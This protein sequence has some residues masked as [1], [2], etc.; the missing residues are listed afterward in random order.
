MALN[1]SVGDQAWLKNLQGLLGYAYVA[2]F[3]DKS[4]VKV[5]S[6]QDHS[7]AL[8]FDVDL[9]H[10]VSPLGTI[11]GVHGST[12][13]DKKEPAI[14][15]HAVHALHKPIPQDQ[16]VQNLAQKDEIQITG[17]TST[18]RLA[19]AIDVAMDAAGGKYGKDV[20]AEFN[21]VLS[22]M[23]ALNRVEGFEDL[24]LDPAMRASPSADPRARADLYSHVAFSMS[25]ED[26][27]QNLSFVERRA[28]G[29]VNDILAGRAPA[30][31]ASQQ[32]FFDKMRGGGYAWSKQGNLRPTADRVIGTS[33]GGITSYDAVLGSGLK[34][35][36]TKWSIDKGGIQAFP[37]V[38]T[39]DEG[40]AEVIKQ[41][42]PGSSDSGALYRTS[43]SILPGEKSPR[44][45]EVRT[46]VLG[47]T[48]LPGA[49]WRYYNPET[50][51]QR[52]DMYIREGVVRKSLPEGITPEA[53]MR[54]DIKFNFPSKRGQSYGFG[55][56]KFQVGKVTIGEK[57]HD[58]D[59]SKGQSP[60][61]ASGEQV[62]ALPKYYNPVRAAWSMGGQ[63]GDVST[64]KMIS[65]LQE[66]NPTLSFVADTLDQVE[67]RMRGNFQTAVRTRGDG[68]KI[69]EAPT[70]QMWW[71]EKAD[72]FIDIFTAE[73]KSPK[74]LTGWYEGASPSE[75]S[76]FLGEWS[77]LRGEGD[78]T[79]QAALTSATRQLEKS[80]TVDWEKVN[81]AYR[82]ASK[83]KYGG[84]AQELRE[85]IM[86]ETVIEAAPQDRVLNE[87]LLGLGVG[88]LESNRPIDLG[89]MT[90]TNFD[91]MV[92]TLE[93]AY[94]NEGFSKEEAAKKARERY[95]LGNKQ[96]ETGMPIAQEHVTE[97]LLMIRTAESLVS[98]NAT[99]RSSENIAF[100]QSITDLD[101]ELARDIGLHVEDFERLGPAERSSASLYSWLLHTQDIKHGQGSSLSPA[102]VKQMSREDMIAIDMLRDQEGMTNSEYAQ[103]IAAQ[104]GIA[105]EFTML[106]VGENLLPNPLAIA[107]KQ[108]EEY[109]QEIGGLSKD[110]RKA[111]EGTVRS[112]LYEDDPILRGSSQQQAQSRLYNRIFGLREGL[113]ENAMSK[114]SASGFTFLQTPFGAVEG[115]SMGQ[116]MLEPLGRRLAKKFKQPFKRAMDFLQQN[117]IPMGANRFPQVQGTA[118]SLDVAEHIP[119]SR[120]EQQIGSE[121]FA[122]MQ[123]PRDYGTVKSGFQWAVKL[124][125]DFDR[126]IGHGA[127]FIKKGAQGLMSFGQEFIKRGLQS[128]LDQEKG[129][130]HNQAARDSANAFVQSGID[131]VRGVNVAAKAMAKRTT[132]PYRELLEQTLNISQPGKN[133]GIGYNIGSSLA[134]AAEGAGISSP[135]IYGIQ[136][137]YSQALD[138][139]GARAPA[140]S[141]A[142]SSA[143]FSHDYDK[144]GSMFLGYSTEQEDSDYKKSKRLEV[145]I[146]EGGIEMRGMQEFYSQYQKDV[147][148][149]IDI[150]DG[151]DV[152]PIGP[153]TAASMFARDDEHYG[154]LFQK[155]SGMDQSKWAGELVSDTQAYYDDYS[156][157]PNDARAILVEKREKDRTIAS[158][159]GM[160]ALFGRA[161]S[162]I[163]QDDPNETQLTAAAGIASYLTGG[164]PDE[165]LQDWRAIG[166]RDQTLRKNKYATPS[167]MLGASSFGALGKPTT[168]IGRA[169][170]RLSKMFG[171]VPK[172]PATVASPVTIQSPRAQIESELFSPNI[173]PERKQE[174]ITQARAMDDKNLP[175]AEMSDASLVNDLRDVVSQATPVDDDSWDATQARLREEM[176]EPTLAES[177]ASA[178]GGGDSGRGG[179]GTGGRGGDDG[180]FG[181]G[182]RFGPRM[183]AEKA[184]EMIAKAYGGLT[185]HGQ[186]IRAA[187]SDIRTELEPYGFGNV[188]AWE[189]LDKL[190]MTDPKAAAAIRGRHA[191]VSK[192]ALQL[193]RDIRS[194][195]A[196]RN[197]SHFMPDDPI[198][199]QLEA[200]SVGPTGT[201][202]S[203]MGGVGL[204]VISGDQKIN[205]ALI[206]MVDELQGSEGFQDL[207]AQMQEAGV[208]SGAKGAMLSGMRKVFAS[209]PA[210]K[211]MVNRAMRL[212]TAVPEQLR[213]TLVGEEMSQIAD[214]G[215]AAKRSSETLMKESN[216]QI[217]VNPETL[218][219]IKGLNE[220]IS[221]LE[222]VAKELTP[223]IG[224]MTKEQ[225]KQR[226]EI[227][228]NIDLRK[229]EAGKIT[230][231]AVAEAARERAGELRK[232]W[233]V[234]QDTATLDK[235]AKLD[236]TASQQQ[237]IAEQFQTEEE[238]AN[239][240]P[241]GR[242]ARRMLGGFGLMYARSVFNLA[243]SGLGWGQG[244]RQEMEN[245]LG[246]T[247]YQRLGTLSLPYDQGRDL[248]NQTALAGQAY[249]PLTGF[250]QLMAE[251]PAA[252]DV[253]NIGGAGMGAWMYSQFAASTMKGQPMGKFLNDYSGAIGVGT[254][255]V[256]GIADIYSRAQDPWGLGTRL[257]R[258][259]LF[260]PMDNLASM[261]MREMA[262]EGF[263]ESER[264][265]AAT[266]LMREQ[267]EQGGTGGLGEFEYTGR[268]QVTDPSKVVGVDAQ[269]VF[270]RG[271]LYEDYTTTGSLSKFEE[272]QLQAQEMV[273]QGAAPTFEAAGL[274]AAFRSVYMPGM[275]IN[276]Q[277]LS[278]LATDY[279]MGGRAEKQAIGA[280]SLFDA[281]AKEYAGVQDGQ[282]KLGLL[283][284]GFAE[285]Q[286]DQA[287]QFRFDRGMQF[288]G[289]LSGFR[290]SQEMQD[291]TKSVMGGDPEAAA[292]FRDLMFK[293][294]ELAETPAGTA[295][296]S[297][298][299]AATISR[300][301]G[302]RNVEMPRLSD[303]S[304]DM[305][306]Y[307]AE[308]MASAARSQS[309]VAEQ[310][311][312]MAQQFR[313]QSTQYGRA[314][315]G[316][317]IFN[318]ITSAPQGQEWLLNRIY[319]LD[320][321]AMAATLGPGDWNSLPGVTTMNGT[322]MSASA[323]GFTDFGLSG[324][325]TG[326][327][328]GTS[329]LQMGGITG[330]QMA[331]NIFG[332][333]W[334][335][336][337]AFDQ[338]LIRGMVGGVS[339]GGTVTTLDGQQVSSVGGMMGAS[340]Y[341]AKVNRD[342]E[343]FQIGLQ[344]ER[345][346]LNVSHTKQMWGIE[347]K[348]RQLSYD[349]QM[350]NFAFQQENLDRSEYFGTAF[351][352]MN[353]KQSLMQREWT[354][355]DWGYSDQVRGLQWGWKQED[356]AEES[357]F[358]TGR[359]RRK[360]ERQNERDTTLHNLEGD[361]IDRQ[362]G[363][364][365][366][367]WKLED[368]RH[369]LQK[370][371][372]EENLKMQ[373]RQLNASKEYYEENFKLQE[374]QT[375]LSR[376]HHEAEIALQR[377]AAAAAAQHAERQ[378]R[379]QQTMAQVQIA[380]QHFQGTLKTV[381]D[382]GLES[383][384]AKLLELNPK[385]LE[386][387]GYLD[388]ISKIPFGTTGGSGGGG[389]AGG[390]GGGGL[391]GG[392]GPKP[393]SQVTA[394]TTFI[395]LNRNNGSQQQVINIYLAGEKIQS[396]IV[397]TITKEIS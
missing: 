80:G 247:G 342:Y 171:I 9:M 226:E 77:G 23:Y 211:E 229:H 215:A 53:L 128:V 307:Q 350:Q 168:L 212:R 75:L 296:S 10:N 95:S 52:P 69:G 396:F 105:D 141:S 265:R 231:S 59:W 11:V 389:G 101:E 361:Q 94:L 133:M 225:E 213:P 310:R 373:Q 284:L 317:G 346:D 219:R 263:E 341:Q 145:G 191:T 378:Y 22:G 267:Y 313:N 174:L 334:Q 380:T 236:R 113:I 235:I 340:L 100:Q 270:S 92:N 173:T 33:A 163:E 123:D 201:A 87:R 299:D 395:P 139:P 55:D 302:I 234:T 51:E 115:Y 285:L 177:M 209:N 327:S 214:Y 140:L 266:I 198:I 91:I 343:L 359:A 110:Y 119:E 322:Q 38:R 155:L 25:S 144:E 370:Q 99:A 42:E 367:L 148:A 50:A 237:G 220:E 18:N 228:K 8:T 295:L 391:G 251:T 6:V 34:I 83:G 16:R 374:R 377:R 85:M 182:R 204:N 132:M 384:K 147:L 135:D 283:Q 57:E 68:W 121:T 390:G 41:M 253:L 185:R 277:R 194:A 104:A 372:F 321:I 360:A 39:L 289:S 40:G 126:D 78:A 48:T 240:G 222:K 122:R 179:S 294:E 183:S 366:E 63:E 172:T 241:M 280:M 64:S 238:E 279:A 170:H 388:I 54:G 268:R 344:N 157:D 176:G 187:F 392:G 339:L 355:E 304:A 300:R 71:E 312:G 137:I 347:D 245:A 125:G 218:A 70:G 81:R 14:F 103:A 106:G 281:S 21:T 305:D 264:A 260:S 262:P 7:K 28:K 73:A 74:A 98:D 337:A 352:Q 112:E 124:T 166:A 1:V 290:K 109:D 368:E 136:A 375:K 256:S 165:L 244:Q 250:S 156:S 252:R 116:E 255:V 351:M 282:S 161:M 206:E 246:A 382:N 197:R 86:R 143:R 269:R 47:N 358:M 32:E 353:R 329:S 224:K 2:Q 333:G 345:L 196:V 315:V 20:N 67:Y 331:N 43:A 275:A 37:A 26:P 72:R 3:V 357:R 199:E 319:N 349:Y 149:P 325:P 230:A 44:A 291:V 297:A 111:V 162:K 200:A 181:G 60:F 65:V 394:P 328:W 271:K 208:F 164:K 272:F 190:S 130:I 386:M 336:N 379:L 117:T 330:A 13:Q 29:L 223:E 323:L 31:L 158:T 387:A 131:I 186:E 232:E 298:F 45:Y 309:Y 303:Y 134:A 195:H 258:D 27:N 362:R 356:F 138:R 24:A 167:T 114:H 286:M 287:D 257:G 376:A 332:S 84:D 56:A 335:G 49:G 397:D 184:N 46:K 274:T 261:A 324:R 393:T 316:E 348:Q 243:T 17:R 202:I 338:G 354:Q 107:T 12:G 273:N 227:Q 93:R 233:L 146:G 371:Q 221:K 276:D 254:A 180:E 188:P 193:K 369:K 320:P 79:S 363:R 159:I 385:L 248:Q 381:A 62:I 217:Q 160:R 365:E 19:I 97:P 142:M 154:Q 318:A 293:L 210:A 15:H 189:A 216:V 203:Q 5:H 4:R 102:R 90:Q 205:P 207:H 96:T 178:G 326:M 242:F 169:L 118:A 35:S 175:I 76:S 30:P 292:Q 383:V 314:D 249:N 120:L 82:R 61:H 153:E 150:I 364:Q 301:A 89:P 66:Q 152:Y 278:V 239:V 308:Q 192:R 259:G 129:I 88:W 36:A 306:P 108:Y 288:A 58:I 127:M 311:L 151:K